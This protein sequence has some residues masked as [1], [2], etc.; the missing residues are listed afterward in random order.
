[1]NIKRFYRLPILAILIITSAFFNLNCSEKENI[2]IKEQTHD[3]KAINKEP[4][5]NYSNKNG[6]PDSTNNLEK[7]DLVFI[8]TYTSGS[9]TGIYVYKM[10]TST[11]S[12]SYVCTSPK[13]IDP[14]YLAIHSNKKWIYA[15][16]E[17]SGTV[18]A[19]SFDSA[20]NKIA[21]INSVSSQGSGPCFVSIDNT[22]KFILVANYNS[23]SV[24][25]C[26]IKA[27]GSLGAATSADQ[28]T[29]SGP[30]AGRQDGP[31]AHMIIQGTNNFVYNTDLG[32][33]KIL[34][35]SLDTTNGH[36]TSTGHDVSSVAGAGP[37]HIAFHPSQPWAYVVCELN[38]T[39]EAFNINNSTSAITRFQ[40]ISTISDNDSSSAAS[41]DIHITP[42]GKYLYASNRGPNNIAMYS[43]NQS[44]GELNNIG[45][46]SVGGTTP[47]NFVID[48]SGKF[49]LVACQDNSRIITF[50]INSANGLLISTG[51]QITVPNPVCLK[52]IEVL[53]EK[54]NTDI[55]VIHFKNK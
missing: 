53:K 54:I 49:L 30:V 38:G 48:P 13:T 14:S 15:V 44:T 22:G 21:S 29:G 4:I 37:R 51:L 25:V 24:A 3:S 36:I 27:N 8:G 7:T 17:S 2:L 43:I 12:L 35:Y 47:R 1:M 10:D 18:T 6:V 19:F 11:G 40:N 55:P 39:I 41:A 20:Q 16:N 34:V 9:S 28:H 50:K 26:P 31:H 33:D 42:D 46:Q 52:F 23:G 45:Y 32:I 5:S